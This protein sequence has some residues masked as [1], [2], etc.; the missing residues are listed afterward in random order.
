MRYNCMTYALKVEDSTTTSLRSLNWTL[1]P[2]EAVKDI[3]CECNR[4]ARKISDL[5]SPIE[6][7]EWRII[8][9]GFVPLHR[10]YEGTVDKY[11]Y[12]FVLQNE[13]GTYSERE[14][15]GATP[16]SINLDELTAAY[17]EFG[18][19]ITYFAVKKLEE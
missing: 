12:H 4:K 7:D 15:W 14:T 10:D 3:C 19:E 18:I 2:E 17:K 13:D 8:F 16:Q 5:N 9:F 6:K 11:D 1:T